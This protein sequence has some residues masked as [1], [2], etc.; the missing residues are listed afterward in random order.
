LY[1]GGDEWKDEPVLLQPVVGEMESP[2]TI[3]VP[4]VL[5]GMSLP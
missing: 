2:G 1:A 4:A 3:R 5:R